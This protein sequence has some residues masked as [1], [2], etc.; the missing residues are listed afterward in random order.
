[1]NHFR[2]C[3]SRLCTVTTT[4]LPKSRASNANDADGV[5]WKWTT[6]DVPERFRM[7]RQ[8]R[9]HE[10]VEVLAARAVDVPQLHTLVGRRPGRAPRG[11]VTTTSWPSC[12]SRGATASMTLSTPP[13]CPGM[14][15]LP[16]WAIRRVS[17]HR[18]TTPRLEGR[19]RSAR[20]CTG[21]HRCATLAP[22]RRCFSSSCC[23]PRARAVHRA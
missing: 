8:Q 1:M 7:V 15:R 14:P 19:A 22:N 16:I 21:P 17:R 13:R 5:L 3:H 10:G 2:R 18:A 4:F 12:A 9:T 23:Q 11:A 20:C 6:S